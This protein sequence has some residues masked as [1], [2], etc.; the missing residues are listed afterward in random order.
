[1][2]P[3]IQSAIINAVPASAATRAIGLSLGSIF[4]GQFIQPFVM[5]P[6]RSLLGVQEMFVWVGSAG[7]GLALL[8]ILGATRV[9]VGS[10]PSA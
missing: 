10:V 9:G 8:T 7:L 4:L 1:M 5:A 6:L 3:L 2:A